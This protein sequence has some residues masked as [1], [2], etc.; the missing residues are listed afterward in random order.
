[1][2]LPISTLL[3]NSKDEA[4]LAGRM[5][6]QGQE[7]NRPGPDY[8][9]MQAQQAAVD[10][11]PTLQEQDTWVHPTGGQPKSVALIA[12][13]WSKSAYVD[14][15]IKHHGGINTDEIWTLNTGAR[16]FHSDLCFVM[17]DLIGEEAADKPY[18]KY[19]RQ[20]Q[21]PLISNTFYPGFDPCFE[22]PLRQVHDHIGKQNWL[23]PNN[24]VPYIITYAM[25]IGVQ[26]LFIC[27]ADYVRP[28]GSVIEDGKSCVLYYL[29]L[30][31]ARGMN[32]ACPGNS[33]L[34]NFHSYYGYLRQPDTSK[35]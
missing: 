17:D 3:K 10:A 9:T 2:A 5:A 4:E 8:T 32:I 16:V 23:K 28:D 30:A 14:Q 15:Q 31:R 21:L 33:N 18:G 26:T 6:M 35:W 27:G 13:G 12:L 1:M 25:Y 24:S 19:L 11:I 22:Y 20:M 7:K 34:L 29:G